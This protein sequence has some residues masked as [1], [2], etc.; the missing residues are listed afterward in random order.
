MSI[1]NDLIND[2]FYAG[3][4]MTLPD[5]RFFEPNKKFWK[6]LSKLGIPSFIDCGTGNGDL[7]REASGN[8]IRMSGCD[9][10]QR[11]TLDPSVHML[12]AHRMPFGEKISALVC[13][14]DHSGWVEALVPI[15][16]EKGARFIYVGLPDNVD[17][18]FPDH[19]K[20]EVLAKKVGK[21]GEVMLEVTR[22]E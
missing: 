20:L 4:E 10:N 16:L 15:V 7:P 17:N 21:D 14:P 13:R 9:T 2:R 22:I 3:S 19:Y 6:E 18:D 1:I 11:E 5:G 8:S 12:P